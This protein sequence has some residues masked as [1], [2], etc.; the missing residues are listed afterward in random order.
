MST[1]YKLQTCFVSKVRI[2]SQREIKPIT[3][4]IYT[5]WET[6]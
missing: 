1:Y 4:H 6:C 2:F 5:V 3:Y